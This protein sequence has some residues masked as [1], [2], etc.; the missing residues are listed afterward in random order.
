MHGEGSSGE[1][2]WRPFASHSG[3]DIVHVD[4]TQ[5]D[6]HDQAACTWLDRNERERLQR[7][8]VDSARRQ[9]VRCRAALRA[10]LC[11]SLGCRNDALAFG[12]GEHG[13]L[14]A[15]V[16]G[17]AVG[18][19]FNVSHSGEHGLIAYGADGVWLG[20]DLE[21]RDSRADL[22]SVSEMVFG[23]TERAALAKLSG[24][25]WIHLFFRLW[26]MKEAL[27]KALGTGFTLDP[28]RFEVPSAMLGGGLSSPFRFPHAPERQW[29]VAD[30]GETRF[31]AAL[32]WET[33]AVAK[34]R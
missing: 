3:I 9:F 1:S 23:A 26:T 17:R 29:M 13:K 22:R 28:A 18:A 7:F 20:I 6:R 24:Q 25:D 8:Q 16:G 5:A 14:F 15:R 31:A 32:A 4:L 19:G 30:L 11:E 21:T 34:D 2:W 27:I 33:N 12:T 10:G